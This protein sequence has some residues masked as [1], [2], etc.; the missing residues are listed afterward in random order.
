M[1]ERMHGVPGDGMCCLLK[2]VLV[3]SVAQLLCF[4]CT[5]SVPDV[6]R[7]RAALSYWESAFLVFFCVTVLIAATGDDVSFCYWRVG[8]GGGEECWVKL[9]LH[10]AP[11]VEPELVSSSLIKLSPF[12]LIFSLETT[13]LL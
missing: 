1:L 12:G 7:G 9:L 13:D 6:G 5:T 3:P 10:H 11:K 4:T 2:A 8:V